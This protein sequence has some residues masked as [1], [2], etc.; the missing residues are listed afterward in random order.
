MEQV[1]SESENIEM[2][3]RPRYRVIA[4][5]PGCPFDVDEILVQDLNTVGEIFVNIH[6]V[7]HSRQDRNWIGPDQIG[8]YPHLFQPLAWYQDREVADMPQYLKSGYEVY[9]VE[10]HFKM[11][12]H[13][14][15]KT[16][17]DQWS[18]FISTNGTSRN[19]IF[20]LPA[21][22]AEYIQYTTKTQP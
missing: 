20:Y 18:H 8:K 14:D 15:D 16:I 9:K 6:H 11:L 19:Y 22:E 17:Y 4:D 3:L 21:T 7:D 2:L 13:H 1:I 12:S 5:Y 10:H